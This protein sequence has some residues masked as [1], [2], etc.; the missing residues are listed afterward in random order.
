M[1]WGDSR[2]E[3]RRKCLNVATLLLFGKTR[4]KKN[5][6]SGV[7]HLGRD[8]QPSLVT[9]VVEQDNAH[10]IALEHS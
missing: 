6:Q 3:S 1:K 7:S 5:K 9:V 8:K 2:S 10:S 4:L